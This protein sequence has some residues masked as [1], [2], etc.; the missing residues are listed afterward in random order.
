M[1]RELPFSSF[2]PSSRRGIGEPSSHY[3]RK[4][5]VIPQPDTG[6]RR[7]KRR[8]ANHLLDFPTRD[9]RF[10]NLSIGTREREKAL[11]ARQRALRRAHYSRRAK[12]PPSK[13]V[14]ILKSSLIS[15]HSG[16]PRVFRLEA[17]AAVVAFPPPFLPPSFGNL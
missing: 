9:R 4:R 7:L 11:H 10:E 17:R 15:V 13:G 12:V 2:V 8:Q 16:S 3:E 6:K 1:E 5:L 14:P